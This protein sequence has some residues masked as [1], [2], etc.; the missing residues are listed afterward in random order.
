[1]DLSALLPA[2]EGAVGLDRLRRRMSEEDGR[3][4]P[5]TLGVTDGAKAAVIAALSRGGRPTLIIN[6]KP[7]HAEGLADELE[8]W[9]GAGSIARVRRFP[10]RDALPYERL[11]PDPDD[12]ASRLAAIQAL[13]EGGPVIV[14]ACAA[15]VAQRTISPGRSNGRA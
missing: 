3:H 15:A 10:E 8:A 7:Q 12:V 4:T 2:L 1:M 5:L 9:L 13:R 6:P 11:A 14:V